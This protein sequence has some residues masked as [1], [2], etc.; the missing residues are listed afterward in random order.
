M[1]VVPT[2]SIDG[3]VVVGFTTSDYLM[4]DADLKKPDEV[5]EWA[6]KYAKKYRLGSVLI[7]KTSDSFQLDLYGNR[8]YNFSIIFGEH[9]PWQEIML[10]INNALKDKIV[11]KKF[12]KMR[13]QGFITE[14]VSRK[15]K[16]IDYPKYFKYIPNGDNEGVFEY[17]RWRAWYKNVGESLLRDS[18][19]IDSLHVS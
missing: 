10:H 16:Q 9:L 7:M 4:L 2:R 13:F 11:D 3:T 1:S 18:R 12:V 15:N 17:L 6:K 8:L 19:E 14:R 5:V